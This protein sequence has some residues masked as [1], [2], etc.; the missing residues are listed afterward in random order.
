[1]EL[2]HDVFS[3]LPQHE[4]LTGAR[5][6]R[7]K[8][9]FGDDGDG[10]NMEEEEEAAEEPFDHEEE[11]E[12]EEGQGEASASEEEGKEL[13][14]YERMKRSKRKEIAALEEELVAERW[15]T[16]RSRS[17]VYC[18]HTYYMHPLSHGLDWTGLD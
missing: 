6:L 3:S 8:D 1:M 11:E 9:F 13:T 10:G 17:C 18:V 4:Y 16:G 2:T 7:Y 12:E 14:A 5:E 15:V